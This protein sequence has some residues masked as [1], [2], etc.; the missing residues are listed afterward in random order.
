[1]GYPLTGLGLLLATADFILVVYGIVQLVLY[2]I[3]KLPWAE[4]YWY[5]DGSGYEKGS[6]RPVRKRILLKIWVVCGLLVVTTILD[7]ILLN[8][9]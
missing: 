5:P 1:M 2:T 8:I 7:Y 3:L 9:F 4:N 6:T